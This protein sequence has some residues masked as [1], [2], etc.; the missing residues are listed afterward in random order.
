MVEG[1]DEAVVERGAALGAQAH[2]ALG[3]LDA[4]TGE[5]RRQVR[6]VVEGDDREFVALGDH[7]LEEVGG[8]LNGL[9]QAF[10]HRRRHVEQDGADERRVVDPFEAH[11]LLDHAVLE[12]LKGVLPE[13]EQGTALT[14]VDGV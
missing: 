14:V 2:Q 1:E 13:V 9:L 6:A 4:V 11:D 10:L 3:E 12:H 5:G 7:L 8:G